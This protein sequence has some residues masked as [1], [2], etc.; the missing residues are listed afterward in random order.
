M[1]RYRAKT[2]GGSPII[3][4]WADDEEEARARIREQLD[5]PGRRP[6][7][8]QWEESGE[9]VEA[10]A[11]T[12]LL[13]CRICQVAQAGPDGLCDGCRSATIVERSRTR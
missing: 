7:L 12:P 6:F 11:E 3:S 5:R 9:I 8:R 2:K 10:G 1:K 4:V 13:D